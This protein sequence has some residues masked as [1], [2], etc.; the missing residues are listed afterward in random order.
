MVLVGRIARAH[1]L[2]GHVVVTPETDF[3]QERFAAGATLWTRSAAGDEALAIA[4]SR[5]QGGRPV[6]GFEGV[7]T[8]EAVE[9]LVGQELRVPQEMLAPLDANTYYQHELVGC[10]VETLGG[11]RIGE[12][13]AVQGGAGASL[14]VVNG[15]R[16]EILVPLALDICVGVDV[17]AKR[18]RVQP[19]EGL[20]EL[21]QTVDGRQQ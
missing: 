16:G 15:A 3:I 18:I 17:Q 7:D 2:R 10:V 4:S 19:P 13:A 8:I 9:R 6:I 12:V 5:V 1:G 11:D 20:L 21:N 14:L